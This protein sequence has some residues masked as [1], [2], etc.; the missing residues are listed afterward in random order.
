M[1]REDA[2][3][4]DLNII[5]KAFWNDYFKTLTPQ[6]INKNDVKVSNPLDQALKDLGDACENILDIGT[7]QGYCLFTSYLLGHQVKYGL[8]ID[9]SEHA[10]DFARKTAKMSE[11]FGLNFEEGDHTCLH[12]LAEASF[13]GIICSNVLDVIPYQTSDDVIKIMD[14]LLKPGGILLL[15]FNFYLTDE[16][17]KKLEMEEIEANTYRMNGVLRAVNLTTK[18]WIKRFEGYDLIRT[19][20]YERIPDGPKDRVIMLKKAVW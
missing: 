12:D 19:E 16:R 5:L 1:D 10:I 13:D 2:K 4:E 6:V 8:G 3:T 14:R 20:Q 7:G 17:I 15:K 11:L 18:D 9:P